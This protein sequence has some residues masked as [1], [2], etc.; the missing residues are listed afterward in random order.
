MC[1]LLV[2]FTAD[3]LSSWNAFRRQHDLSR[4]FFY[5]SQ[6][7]RLEQRERQVASYDVERRQGLEIYIRTLLDAFNFIEPSAQSLVGG[8][9]RERFEQLLRN[10]TP[11]PGDAERATA[12][13]EPQ[14]PHEFKLS[15]GT[16]GTLVVALTAITLVVLGGLVFPAAF[17]G[18]LLLRAMGFAVVTDDNLEVTPL[19]ALARGAIAWVPAIVFIAIAAQRAPSMLGRTFM[20]TYPGTGSALL[21]CSRPLPFGA[22]R[23]GGSHR[24]RRLGGQPTD[25]RTAGSVDRHLAGASMIIASSISVVTRCFRQF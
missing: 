15:A 11:S 17:R 5:V 21:P 7:E 4:I 2:V 22:S 12:V 20:T 9:A 8:T 3:S 10:P 18:G 14:V 6:L 1:A 13:W 24:G 25:S 23:I 19:R 16:R